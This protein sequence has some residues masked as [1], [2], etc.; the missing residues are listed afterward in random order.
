MEWGGD[1]WLVG[2][3][4]HVILVSA[5]VLMVLTLGLWT[6]DWGLTIRKLRESMTSAQSLFISFDSLISKSR[7][8]FYI[9]VYIALH[10]LIFSLL[11]FS[12]IQ[13]GVLKYSAM[14]IQNTDYD[15]HIRSSYKSFHNNPRFTDVTL[16]TEDF[17]AIQGHKI[18]LS[19]ASPLF[20][21]LLI[22]N[23]PLVYLRGVK[24]DHLKNIFEYI[25]TGSVSLKEE[26]VNVF[27]SLAQEL[28]LQGMRS[29]DKHHE[30]QSHHSA[31]ENNPEE[32]TMPSNSTLPNQETVN[33]QTETP[34]DSQQ[35]KKYACNQCD[36]SSSQKA[37]LK[38]HASSRHKSTFSCELCDYT[39]ASETH[40]KIHKNYIHSIKSESTGEEEPNEELEK[41]LQEDYEE[42]GVESTDE[43]MV[44]DDLSSFEKTQLQDN[45]KNIN[46]TQCPGCDKILSNKMNTIRHFRMVHMKERFFCDVC[47]AS[48]ASQDRVK[49]HMKSKHTNL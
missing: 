18:I 28:E 49:L 8:L 40:L 36:Y 33:K 7:W 39:T 4:A 22:F 5:K 29:K 44:T 1:R 37:N 13:A 20:D 24:S 30:P 47:S 38:R 6:S 45:L 26:Q 17:E 12:S 15:D 14:N 16:I 42:N 32:S 21:K 41:L 43:E 9:L 2:V 10:W 46:S 25:Y 35:S 48:Y 3:V 34:P 27:I 11:D 19:Q 31:Q 23:N